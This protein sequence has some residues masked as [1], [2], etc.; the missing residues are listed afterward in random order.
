M[1]LVKAMHLV[2]KEDGFL[3]AAGLLVFGA[4]DGLAD[5]LDAGEHCR[6]RLEMAVAGGGDYARQRGLADTGWAP[7]DHRVRLLFVDGLKDGLARAQQMRLADKLG[8]RART[9]PCCQWLVGGAGLFI[10]KQGIGTG[11]R[12]GSLA[13]HSQFNKITQSP[14]KGDAGSAILTACTISRAATAIAS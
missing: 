14:G 12:H 1:R 4:L 5:V 13:G 11:V 9:Q 8:H 3:V 2:D 10:G 6:E 7:Q